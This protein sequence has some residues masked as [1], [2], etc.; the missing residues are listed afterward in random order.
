M[1]PI[2]S[3]YPNSTRIQLYGLKMKTNRTKYYNKMEEYEMKKRK[4]ESTLANENSSSTTIVLSDKEEGEAADGG[5]VESAALVRSSRGLRDRGRGCW[6]GKIEG[7]DRAWGRGRGDWCGCC[8]ERRWRWLQR[9]V[10]PA[11]AVDK[12]LIGIGIPHFLSPL[13]LSVCD[14]MI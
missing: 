11:A 4:K 8:R 3:I 12:A 5:G 1:R 13:S 6:Q 10:P 9:M 14:N 2:S 7:L